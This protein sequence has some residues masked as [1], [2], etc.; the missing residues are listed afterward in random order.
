MF[1]NEN[2]K[3]FFN[4]LSYE[5]LDSCLTKDEIHCIEE[6]NGVKIPEQYRDFLLYIG[7]GIK[8]NS[9]NIIRGIRRPVHKFKSKRISYRFLFLEGMNMYYNI[10]EKPYP[11]Y[12][13]AFPQYEDCFDP[14]EL[15][16]G[17]K[18]CKHYME[19]IDTL[20]NDN[21]FNDYQDNAY[22]NGCFD[23]KDTR[24][25]IFTG[26]ARGQVWRSPEE[27]SG[28]LYPEFKDFFEYVKFMANE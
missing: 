6:N 26:D 27:D 21:P 9:G 8:L 14:V 18:E 23:M 17:C 11:R 24:K 25:L 19:C 5:I 15:E 4:E 2:I 13:N 12:D 16:N 7:N 28:V 1:V 20:Y 10:E 22:F 3:A